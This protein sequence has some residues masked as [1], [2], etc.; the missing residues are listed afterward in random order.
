[1]VDP[2]DRRRRIITIALPSA[3]QSANTQT[4]T[5]TQAASGRVVYDGR[6]ASCHQADLRGFGEAPPLT[7]AAFRARWL[8]TNAERL[9]SYVQSSMPP[10]GSR[11]T[12]ND[13]TNVTAFLTL[14][15]RPL[16][17]SAP[18]T[19]APAPSPAPALAAT[20]TRAVP[21][22]GQS[23]AGVIENYVPVTDEMLRDPPAGDWLM[24]R[25]TYQGWSYSP[26]EEITR[27]NVG[28]LRLAWMWAMSDQD[29]ANQPM[30]LVHNGIIYLVG[31]GGVVQ[32][33]NGK[34]GDLIWESEVGPGEAVSIG[35]MR[36]L[37]IYD[38]ALLVATTD[39]RLVALDARDGHMVWETTL[40]DRAKGFAN[41]GGPIV[42]KGR[43]I[44]GLGGCDRFGPDRCFIS[45]HDVKTG[46]LLWKF[47]T[48]AHAG[49]PGGDT[50]GELP[51]SFRKGGETWIAGSYD[52][53]LNLT[54]WGIAQAKPWMH[55]SRGT[56]AK[57]AALYT[58][59]TVALNADDGKLA[60]HYQ[61]APGESLDLDEV[62]ERVLVDIG[63]QKVLF[64]IGKAGILWKLDRRSGAYLAHR[65]TVFQNVFDSFDP[66]TGVPTYRPDIIEQRVEQW[67]QA[68]PS[69]EGGHNWQAMS[70]HQPTGLLVI[71]LSQS[72]MEI[73]GRRSR[74]SGRGRRGRGRSPV[75]RNARIGRQHRQAGRVRCRDDEGSVELSAARAVSDVGAV[76]RGGTGVCRRPRS[77]LPRL[78]R[79][80]GQDLVGDAARH[81]G[82]GL[83]GIVHRRRK[84]VHRGDDGPGRRQPTHGAAHDRARDPSAEQ[85]RRVVRVRAAE[86]DRF[87]VP[88][89]RFQVLVPGSSAGFIVRGSRSCVPILRVDERSWGRV[90][91][92]GATRRQDPKSVNSR[93]SRSSR[94]I[95]SAPIVSRCRDRRRA[96]RQG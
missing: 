38:E 40:E 55:A 71:P 30:P 48:V 60:W 39:A 64:T 11:L 86:L 5:P 69:T 27:A 37:A 17:G 36:N 23:V 67:I 31:T 82:A 45:A 46:R 79:A 2:T 19:L 12:A 29:G 73:S 78:R 35:S 89:S 43:A 63:E 57:D 56:T 9:G 91:P 65:E 75:L 76:Y 44:Q 16:N 7:G 80:D 85:R 96:D 15:N 90:A 54:Y 4:F 53:D 77:A 51:D 93:E 88:R 81:V 6:C 59:S 62:F 18:T 3:Q 14:I 83:P 58:S 95:N 20:T 8:D 42:A 28:G 70:Y 41:S 87:R 47:N 1:V 24:A 92:G 33:L 25:R 72:C 34:T 94:H 66:V 32:A 74:S 26:L 52:P 49:E 61:H 21:R 22:R 13:A 50:W 68:C 10:S 84:T